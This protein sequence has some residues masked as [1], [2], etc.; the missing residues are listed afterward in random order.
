M[1]PMMAEI[2]A[3]TIA[4]PVDPPAIEFSSLAFEA[5][6]LGA[7]QAGLEALIADPGSVEI[8]LAG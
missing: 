2:A 1:K 4:Y 3:R 6:C 5:A 7:A 8:A